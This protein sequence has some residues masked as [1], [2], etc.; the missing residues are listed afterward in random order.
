MVQVAEALESHLLCAQCTK[1]PS[2]D[3]ERG[4]LPELESC[5]SAQFVAVQN[6]RGLLPTREDVEE[7]EHLSVGG[8]LM[9]Q[10]RAEVGGGLQQLLAHALRNRRAVHAPRVECARRRVVHGPRHVLSTAAKPSQNTPACM[11]LHLGFRVLSP[12]HILRD[13]RVSA[14]AN[15]LLIK[16]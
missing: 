1:I 13:G 6:H 7:R 16:G 9:E 8:E 15:P 4:P 5:T 12:R 3:M 11:H 10:A 14:C 2:T